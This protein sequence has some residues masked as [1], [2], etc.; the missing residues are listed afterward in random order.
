MADFENHWKFGLGSTIAGT[1]VANWFHYAH[2]KQ[3]PFLV[4][5]GLVGAIAP[6]IDSDTG[7]PLRIIFGGLAVILPPILLWRTPWLHQGIERAVLFWALSF[8]LI[9]KPAKWLFKTFTKH[10]GVFHSIPAALIF[11]ESIFLLAH[12]EN[13]SPKLQLSMGLMGT[14]GYLTHLILDEI[15]AVDFN[16]VR[17]KKKRSFGTALCWTDSSPKRTMILYLILLILGWIC[18]AQWHGLDLIP[19]NLI[20]SLEKVQH[21]LL[22]KIQLLM[23]QVFILFDQK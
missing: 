10:R 2:P 15:W 3:L 17:F 12:Y 19:P 14:L 13:V 6:D 16:G 20:N 5:A 8:Y 1:F 21:L 11:G 22:S 23:D 9:I 4:L 7:R 18:W